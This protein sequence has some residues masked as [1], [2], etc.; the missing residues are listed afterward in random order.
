[1][2]ESEGMRYIDREKTKSRCLAGMEIHDVRLRL[3]LLA[4]YLKLRR[5]FLVNGVV[6]EYHYS[7]KANQE[8][9]GGFAIM[10][11]AVLC[12]RERDS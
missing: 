8:Y 7:Q 5:D 6:P 4:T 2:K 12:S 10:L 3:E 9:C 11:S 1:M